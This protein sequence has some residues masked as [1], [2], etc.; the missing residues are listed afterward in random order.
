MPGS[1]LLYSTT[2]E[3]SDS[4]PVSIRPKT[5][6]SNQAS[7]IPVAVNPYTPQN[8]IDIKKH[9]MF[10]PRVS[11]R[12]QR[13][14]NNYLFSPKGM[15]DAIAFDKAEQLKAQAAS[16]YATS[17]NVSTLKATM[18]SIVSNAQKQA[19]L[20]AINQ[21]TKALIPKPEVKVEQKPEQKPINTAY[22]NSQ[23]KKFGFNNMEEVKAWQQQNGLVADGMFGDNSEAK[24]RAANPKLVSRQV[25]NAFNNDPIDVVRRS[26]EV[27]NS[28]ELLIPRVWER[29]RFDLNAFAK[30]NGLE[31][32][33]QG[34]AVWDPIGF[35][36][37]YIDPKY[38][39]YSDTPEDYENPGLGYDARQRRRLKLY[40]AMNRIN[41]NTG[42]YGTKIESLH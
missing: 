5:E 39:I 12:E 27:P 16:D 1:D 35:G 26:N 3:S 25:T 37:F 17:R 38:I 10:G 15:Q 33:E 9:E 41:P 30:I 13:K 29:P 19:T 22:W 28:H 36:K 8:F 2:L 42:L 7:N 32:D 34:R 18:P 24:W 20:N 4:T 23:A 31:F 6:I 11:R 21:P 14:F 40:N